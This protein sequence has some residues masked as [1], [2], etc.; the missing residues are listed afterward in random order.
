MFENI[1]SNQIQLHYAPL[2]QICSPYW[3]KMWTV[4]THSPFLGPASHILEQ[5]ILAVNM[6]IGIDMFAE[7]FI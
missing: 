7:H 2:I 6:N 1:F 5:I 3:Q 4:N